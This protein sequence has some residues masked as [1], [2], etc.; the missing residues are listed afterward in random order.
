MRKYVCVALIVGSVLLVPQAAVAAAHES[1]TGNRIITQCTRIDKPGSYVVGENITA[2]ASDLLPWIDQPGTPVAVTLHGCI[3]IA[4][5]FVT[6]DLAGHTI[7][8]SGDFSGLDAGIASDGYHLGA[9]VHAGVVTH[10]NTLIF[11][12]G[13]GHTIAHV[14]GFD[15]FSGAYTVIGKPGGGGG[16]RLI[17]NIGEISMF[18]TCPAVILENVVVASSDG[19]FGGIFTSGIGC[20]LPQNSP[21]P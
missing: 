12:Q 15:D 2:T 21:V 7:A 4:A 13:T 19:T 16:H 11:L 14:R 18:I 3:V 20:T 1:D 17:G 5:D 6:L 8:G 10:F 9:D